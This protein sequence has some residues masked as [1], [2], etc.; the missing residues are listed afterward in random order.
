MRGGSPTQHLIQ[1]C[2][3]GPPVPVTPIERSP[4]ELLILLRKTATREVGRER[5]RLHW[6]EGTKNLVVAEVSDEVRVITERNAYLLRDGEDGLVP[7]RI[8]NIRK[9]STQPIAEAVLKAQERSVGHLIERGHRGVRPASQRIEIPGLE[10]VDCR[11]G[12]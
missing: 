2:G 7:G 3:V 10:S 8:E 9:E 11:V 12:P 6:E 1:H 5:E 4:K